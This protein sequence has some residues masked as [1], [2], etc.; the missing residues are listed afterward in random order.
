MS[1]LIRRQSH[2]QKDIFWHRTAICLG[3]GTDVPLRKCTINTAA[4]KRHNTHTHTYR[5][6]CMS[7][8]LPF[9][10]IRTFDNAKR[11]WPQHAHARTSRSV[12]AFSPRPHAVRPNQWAT[13]ATRR[14]CAESVCVCVHT[15]TNACCVR[16]VHGA[17]RHSRWWHASYIEC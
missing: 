16:R 6:D 7:S 14:A 17:R 8:C 11:V 9:S 2:L 3:L 10:G 15:A 12:V 1:I 4:H 5:C 13:N